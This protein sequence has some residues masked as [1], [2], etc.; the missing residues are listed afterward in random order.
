[1]TIEQTLQ[2]LVAA[3]E[4]DDMVRLFEL[5]D[6]SA[7]KIIDANARSLVREWLFRAWHQNVLDMLA[8]APVA[9]AVSEGMVLVP[10]SAVDWMRKNYPVLCEKS[11]LL[12]EVAAHEPSEKLKQ[13]T[14]Q[15]G[16]CPE[17]RA[18]HPQHHVGCTQQAPAQRLMSEMTLLGVYEAEQQGRWGDHVR[19]LRAIE[20]AVR[21]QIKEQP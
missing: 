1:M 6:S 3:A 11:G 17:C 8:A 14:A 13:D 19:G 21:A 10:S 2:A 18:L 16:H 4:T 12:R 20:S 7:A 15:F 5:L 9:A